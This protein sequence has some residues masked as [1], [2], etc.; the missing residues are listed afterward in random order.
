MSRCSVPAP[1]IYRIFEAYGAQLTE[2]RRRGPSW[3]AVAKSTALVLV[4]TAA[5]VLALE[6]AARLYAHLTKRERGMTFDAVLG[7]RPLPNVQK[8]GDVWGVTRPAT[9]NTDGWRDRE[10]PA[11]KPPGTRRVVAIGDSFT[12]GVGVDDGE[13]FT[14]LLA[15]PADSLDVLNLG[16]AG[17]G[18][19]QELRLLETHVAR[20][21][22][23]DVLLT[24]FVGNDLTDIRYD[25]LYSWPKPYFTLEAGQ[26]VPRP[27]R[28]TWDIRLRT[29]SYLVEFVHQ[30]APRS[31][32]AH[33]APELASVDSLAL[34]DAIFGRIATVTTRMGARLLV[35]LAYP[36]DQIRGSPSIFARH[37]AAALDSAKIPWVDTRATFE[38]V[39]D[40]ASALYFAKNGHWNP[41]GH[42][43]VADAVRR[44]FYR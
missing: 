8:V 14:D 10:H 15:R 19:D 24:I 12:F 6:G 18:P 21:G 30:L 36:P 3:R 34:F 31:F 33:A 20:Y 42:M 13:R 17:Y 44:R 9:T 32:A 40:A 38:G 16:V 7:W 4:S 28:A 5:T 37:V 41:R 22:P 25:R 27:P 2:H 35:V 11:T 43:L 1:F 26:L 39:P 23:D 29:A